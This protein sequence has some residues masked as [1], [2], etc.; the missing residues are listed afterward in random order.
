MHTL[1]LHFKRN[2]TTIMELVFNCLPNKGK[3]SFLFLKQIFTPVKVEIL[4]D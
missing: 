2:V 1:A 4:I 3:I